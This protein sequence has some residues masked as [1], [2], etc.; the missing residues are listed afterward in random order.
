MSIAS[1][2]DHFK[3]I[4]SKIEGQLRDE[5][6]DEILDAIIIQNLKN[7]PDNE[8]KLIF[9]ALIIIDEKLTDNSKP[10]DLINAMNDIL[11][12]LGNFFKLLAPNINS[13]DNNEDIEEKTP[14]QSSTLQ[15]IE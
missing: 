14:S 7:V 4:I 8:K 6:T 12:H 15:N 5:I 13:T 9:G 10:D 1:T 3:N 11:Q 2:R